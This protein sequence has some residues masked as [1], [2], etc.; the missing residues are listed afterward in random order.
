MENSIFASQK[1]EIE[2]SRFLKE[3][4]RDEKGIKD[5]FVRFLDVFSQKEDIALSF[6]SRPGVSYSLRAMRDRAGKKGRPLCAMVDIIDDNP[7]E[8]WLS[9]CFYADTISDPAEEGDLIPAG[10]LGED[11]LCFDVFEHKESIISYL[12]K[13]IDEACASQVRHAD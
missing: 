2:A 11:G 9:V 10:L 6:V 4:P 1:E 8:R 7:Q 5:A 3:W 12:E 13:R